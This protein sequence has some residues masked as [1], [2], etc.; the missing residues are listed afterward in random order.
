MGP[1]IVDSVIALG[2]WQRAAKKIKARLL[3]HNHYGAGTFHVQ[4]CWP[5]LIINWWPFSCRKIAY[6]DFPQDQRKNFKTRVE[7]FEDLISIYKENCYVVSNQ[8]SC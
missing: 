5:E 8:D 1:K 2:E 4:L 3:I 7:M 6:V